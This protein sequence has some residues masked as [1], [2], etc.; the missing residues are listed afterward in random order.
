MFRNVAE[1]V[2]LAESKQVKIAEIM[3]L[4]EMEFSGLSREQIIEKMDRNLTVMEQAVERGLKGVQSVTGLTG[5]D[6]V[7]LQNYIKSGKA[8]AGNLLLDAVSKAVAT[9]EVNA[10]MGMICATPTAGSAGVVPGTLFAVK[11]KLNPTRAE[12]IEFLFTS[13]AFGFVVA[14]NASISGAAGGCQAEVGSASGMAA[15]AI[16]E[17]AGGTPSQAA[18]AMAITLKNMLG[19]VCDP[20]AGLVEVPCVKRNAMGASNAITAADMALAGITSRIPCDEVIDAMYK[21]GLT[22]PVALR[23]T[24]EGGL[25]ATPTGRKLAKEIFGSYK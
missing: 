11:E 2:E 24:A 9:N 14:N 4:Q 8:L 13:A 3:I 12:M 7:L 18:E 1:L 25:A 5:G 19:L 15:A 21:I 23:E 20:V 22:M 16:V 10:A 17:L 6:A